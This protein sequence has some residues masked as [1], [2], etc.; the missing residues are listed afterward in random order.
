VASENE[1]LAVMEVPRELG[2]AVREMI[3]VDYN[4]LS[5]RF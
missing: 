3:A 5:P 1:D 4:A 2:P